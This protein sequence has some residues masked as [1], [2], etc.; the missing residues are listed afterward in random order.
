M[1]QNVQGRRN[2]QF[3]PQQQNVRTYNFHMYNP[4]YEE[5]Y[6]EDQV[7][8]VEVEE[9]AGLGREELALLPRTKH[10]GKD[11]KCTICLCEIEKGEEETFLMC[12]H[13]FHWSCIGDWLHKSVKC[14]VCQFNIRTHLRG[15]L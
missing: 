9:A 7:E 14:P 15:Q 6:Y 4:G 3:P 11:G 8:E 10:E 1:F 2:Y 12:F 5:E 13:S